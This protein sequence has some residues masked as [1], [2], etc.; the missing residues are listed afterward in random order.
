MPTWPADL[1]RSPL[2]DSLRFTGPNRLIATPMDSGPPKVRRK[3][4]RAHRPMQCT[5]E[6]SEDQKLTFQ[7]FVGTDL[8]DGALSFT[9]PDPNSAD[10]GA[11]LARIDPSQMPSYAVI[12]VDKGENVWAVSL[13]LLVLPA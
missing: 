13:S 10:G 5:F 2:R 8:A 11:C 12:G 4:T 7:A 6:M 9:M 1:P 3:F